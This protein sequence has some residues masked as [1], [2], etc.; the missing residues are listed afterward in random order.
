MYV[1]NQYSGPGH[2]DYHGP[3]MFQQGYPGYGGEYDDQ[4]DYFIMSILAI[5]CCFPGCTIPALI[6]SMKARGQFETGRICEGKASA[7]IAKV[8]LITSVVFQ[9]IALT[10]VILYF[11]ID[12]LRKKL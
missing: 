4:S 2:L 10:S 5:F 9:L 3:P 12:N 7:Y 1:Y 6:F 11:A 8:L